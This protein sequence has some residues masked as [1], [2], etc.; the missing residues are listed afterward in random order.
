MN[1]FNQN[2]TFCSLCIAALIVFLGANILLVIE[3]GKLSKSREKVTSA[4]SQ[5]KALMYSEVAP[6][7]RNLEAAKKNLDELNARLLSIY[8]NLQSSTLLE[9]SS[10]NAR[11]V[12]AI[13]RY[14]VN[15]QRRIK[16]HKDLNGVPAPI[17]VPEDFAFGFEKY[18]RTSVLPEGSTVSRLDKQRQ[19][20]SY[21][22]DQLI[23]SSPFTIQS[24]ERELIE[25][26]EKDEN[27]FRIDPVVS[28]RVPG[29]ID[30]LA[31]R[32]TFTGYTPTLRK[33]L[34]NLAYFQLPLVVRSVEADRKETKSTV[35]S[36]VFFRTADNT[37]S[38]Q[39]PVVSETESVFTV[40]LEFIEVISSPDL[41]DERS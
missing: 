15:Y 28:A 25:R 13:Q 35:S 31:F 33:F 8:K 29:V 37:R 3:S 7:V 4:D 36:N 11:V 22:L 19:V 12:S 5:L 20:L 40:T 16:E 9:T 41:K 26:E 24:V 30:T 18:L 2:R 23:A 14:I 6:T 27:S 34:N 21:I 38:D 17:Q 10:D 1:F 39:D 32:V